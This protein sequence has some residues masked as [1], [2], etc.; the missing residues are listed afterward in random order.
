[1]S[2]RWEDDTKK[3]IGNISTS[4]EDQTEVHLSHQTH[5]IGTTDPTLP[6]N[7]DDNHDG[8]D[9]WDGVNIDENRKLLLFIA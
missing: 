6:R 4:G 7:N 9:D 2:I 8:D 5:L 3:K 1:M